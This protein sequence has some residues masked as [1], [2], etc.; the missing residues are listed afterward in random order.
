MPERPDPVVRTTLPNPGRT[1]PTTDSAARRSAT[2]CN[3]IISPRKKN[4]GPEA[5]VAGHPEVPN[6]FT[7]CIH[8]WISGAIR[9]SSTPEPTRA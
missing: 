6:H 5:A 4:G 9:N 7:P 3:R 2:M 1:I 8:F